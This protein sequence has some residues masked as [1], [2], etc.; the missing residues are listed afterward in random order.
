MVPIRNAS[1]GGA[2]EETATAEA[3][4]RDVRGGENWAVFAGL[5]MAEFVNDH[6]R[7]IMFYGLM[8]ANDVL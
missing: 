5:L 1:G 4:A 7:I 8:M 2:A 3:A 6:G